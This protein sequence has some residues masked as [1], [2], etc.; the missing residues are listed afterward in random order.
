MALSKMKRAAMKHR[1]IGIA[2]AAPSGQCKDSKCPWHGSLPV[3]G[4]TFT[5]Q[6]AAAR[7]SRTA[8]VEWGFTV[9]LPKFERFERRHSHVVVHNPPCIEAKAGDTVKIAECR[10]LSKTKKF[11]IVEMV[12][13]EM[14]KK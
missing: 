4:Q 9:W 11:V 8:T 3:R 12:A 6:V 2:A 14:G 5:G 1:N 10:P 13:R 7:S